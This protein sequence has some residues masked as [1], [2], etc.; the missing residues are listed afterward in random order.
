VAAPEVPIPPGV[1]SLTSR[2]D[3]FVRNASGESVTVNAGTPFGFPNPA[4]VIL[5]EEGGGTIVAS[6]FVDIRAGRD[7]RMP[8]GNSISAGSTIYMGSGADIRIAENNSLLANTG[9]SGQKRQVGGA[10]RGLVSG[11]PGITL[12][13]GTNFRR[14]PTRRRCR[15][16]HCS[17]APV[18]RLMP[19]AGISGW[20]GNDR[21]AGASF[22]GGNFSA[23]V[24]SPSA[25]ASAPEPGACAT[26]SICL[27]NV[28]VANAIAIGLGEGGAPL[29]FLGE[30]TLNGSTL[31]IRTS[32]TLAFDGGSAD[33]AD[34]IDLQSTGAGIVSPA[35]T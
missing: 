22:F 34:T 14:Q 18:R 13:A 17:S 27:G 4:D 8:A 29:G 26:G 19:E 9:A 12:S 25:P 11:T 30:G 24:L 2:G 28:N 1:I 21:C 6:D 7:I 10:L 33:I 16:R 3:I 20:K 35:R 23:D 31:D 15:Q 5:G 32:G